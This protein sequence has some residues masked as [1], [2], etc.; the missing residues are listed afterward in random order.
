M[1]D[2]SPKSREKNKKQKSK[3]KA[4]DKAAHDKKQSSQVR[5]PGKT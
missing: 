5:V 1:G 2:K 3:Q 4:K